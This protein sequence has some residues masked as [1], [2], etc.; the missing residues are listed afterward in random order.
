MIIDAIRNRQ[1]VRGY[2]DQPVA[3]EKIERCLEAARLAPSACNSQPWRFVVV[4]DPGLRPQVAVRLSDV[5]MQ[6]NRFAASAPVLVAV[7]AQKPNL[8]ARIGAF[9]KNKPYY[10]IDLG[11][12]AE[13]FCL[14]AAAEGLGS[15]MLGWFD[16]PA[17]R[18]LLAVPSNKR[19]PLVITLG[20]P[21]S[22]E[23]R[24]K[25]RKTIDEIR[26]YNRW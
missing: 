22:G 20:Y 9:L 18:K 13:H 26:T 7:I 4:D 10:L 21:A 19:I 24:P 8:T 11:I 12:A 6:G 23:I 5:I 16:E 15:C 2:T 14:Q 1:S 3:R 17:V 25:V